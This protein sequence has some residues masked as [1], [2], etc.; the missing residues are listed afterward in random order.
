MQDTSRRT[1][2]ARGSARRSIEYSYFFA[3][4][5]ADV[6]RL[7]RR[8]QPERVYGT[9]AF[10]QWIQ[11]PWPRDKPFDEFARDLLTATGSEE[12]D[13]LWS[14]TRSCKRG[15]FVDDIGQVF[16]ACVLT[17]AQVIHH[18]RKPGRSSTKLSG[19]CS[20]L[21]QTTAGSVSSLPVR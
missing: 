17:C 10:H 6:L 1:R 3:N 14:G 2:S 19:V 11:T 4:K 5:W 20:S 13:R 12:T 9:F 16:W 8:G 15:D 21:Y 18:P 7:K